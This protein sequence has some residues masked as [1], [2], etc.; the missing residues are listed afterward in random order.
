MLVI[1]L[2]LCLSDQI[3]KL[4]LGKGFFLSSA[5]AA[6]HTCQHCSRNHENR[7]PGVRLVI[8]RCRVFLTFLLSRICGESGK[9]V[10]PALGSRPMGVMVLLSMWRAVSLRVIAVLGA[11]LDYGRGLRNFQTLRNL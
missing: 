10:V 11:F 1:R 7:Q 3:L 6:S 8:N 2:R 5:R 4:T 9:E